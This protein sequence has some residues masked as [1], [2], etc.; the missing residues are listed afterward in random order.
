MGGE[1]TSRTVLVV[2]DEH[3]VRWSLKRYLESEGYRTIAASCG[4]E[5]M[6]I[7][8]T[9]PVDILITDIIMPKMDGLELIRRALEQHPN[10]RALVITAND[11]VNLLK[12]A[13]EAGALHTF[14]KPIPFQELTG[15]ME[16]L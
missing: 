11:T 3:L 9:V 5:A 14:S 4:E 7:L 1:S 12:S 2:D 16:N 10:L 15:V 13:R 6:E 8:G